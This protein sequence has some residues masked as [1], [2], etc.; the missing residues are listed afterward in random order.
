MKHTTALL[1]LLAPLGAT[2]EPTHGPLDFDPYKMHQELTERQAER[3]A[4]RSSPWLRVEPNQPQAHEVIL[5]NSRLTCFTYP[6]NKL[7]VCR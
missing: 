3:N 6:N 1:L 4:Q 7:S 5:P 2:A